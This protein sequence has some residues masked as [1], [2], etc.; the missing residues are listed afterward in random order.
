MLNM[1]SPSDIE[2]LTKLLQPPKDEDDEENATTQPAITSVS[3]QPYAPFSK[4]SQRIPESEK[5]FTP[6]ITSTRKIDDTNVEEHKVDE[7]NEEKKEIEIEEMIESNLVEPKYNII[8]SQNVTSTDIVYVDPF[9][10]FKNNAVLRIEIIL[11][12]ETVSNI[13]VKIKDDDTTLVL[14]SNKYYLCVALPHKVFNDQYT[15]K[16]YKDNETLK[17]KLKLKNNN[18]LLI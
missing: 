16:W 4:S 2:A 15:A 11:P 3:Q 8:Y 17:L 18:D 12:D 13:D 10:E 6:V 9:S 1:F 5:N 7:S 14:K